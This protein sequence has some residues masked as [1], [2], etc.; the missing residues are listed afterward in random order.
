[1]TDYMIGYM[2]HVSAVRLKY[3]VLYFFFII[4]SLL[5][6]L[7][8]SCSQSCEREAN[9]W[10]IETLRRS[11]HHRSTNEM[12]ILILMFQSFNKE[13][14]PE[15]HMSI[16]IFLQKCLQISPIWWVFELQFVIHIPINNL[17]PIWL[18]IYGVDLD[19]TETTTKLRYFFKLFLIIVLILILIFFIYVVNVIF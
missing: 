6:L 5:S 14:T 18:N 12:D 16:S 9:R 7:S 17:K 11:L 8:L 15:L 2:R 10:S 3:M 4:S 13:K 19:V 1:M